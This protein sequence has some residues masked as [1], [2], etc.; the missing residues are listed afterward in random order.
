[1]KTREH[2]ETTPRA[3]VRTV[4]H[5]PRWHFWRR[6]RTTCRRCEY[7]LG[8]RPCVLRKI[9]PWLTAHLRWNASCVILCSRTQT[10]FRT[11]RSRFMFVVRVCLADRTGTSAAIAALSLPPCVCTVCILQLAAFICYPCTFTPTRSAD[12]GIQDIMRQL[13]PNLSCAPCL[14]SSRMYS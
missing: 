2:T 4:E 12:D 3:E 5:I 9:A 8:G 10:I 7:Y 11:T 1:M 14:I 6:S 13:Q